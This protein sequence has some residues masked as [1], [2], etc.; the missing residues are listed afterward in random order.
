M[1]SDV[2]RAARQNAEWCDLVCRTSGLTPLLSDRRWTSRARTPP[3]YPDAISLRP[4]V[5]AEELVT[6]IDT[7]SGCSVKDSFANLDL[8]Q[9]GFRL[10]FDAAWIWAPPTCTNDRLAAGVTWSV[11]ADP[12]ALLTA[13]LPA[14][15]SVPPVA[16]LANPQIT[17][18]VIVAGS[19]LIGSAIVHG[20]ENAVGLSHV[21]VDIGAAPEQWSQLLTAVR[22]LHPGLPITGY[23]TGP[24]LTA[25]TE[26]GCTPCG[27][28][29]VWSRP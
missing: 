2:E 26:G 4:D 7:S 19:D 17:W 6:L 22:R 25:A 10:L 14:A 21:C 16:V 5:K 29:R 8:A 12:D 11:V 27:P 1:Q 3:D 9:H 15:L 20:A 23:E 18:L 28:L 24:L 13:T